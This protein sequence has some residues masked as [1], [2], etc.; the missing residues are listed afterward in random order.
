MRIGLIVQCLA[1][2]AAL[3]GFASP[4]RTQ[5]IYPKHINAGAQQAIK[6][7]LDYLAKSQSPNGNWTNSADGA[8]YPTVMAA[9]AGMAFLANG[10]TPSRGPYADNVRRV[11]NLSDRQRP[12]HRV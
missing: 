5:E 7:G 2:L 4:L 9:L 6:N 10:N 12:A 3:A 11:E 1:G 8:A